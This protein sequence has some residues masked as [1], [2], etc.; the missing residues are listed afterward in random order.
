MLTT[1]TIEDIL[2]WNRNYKNNR[3]KGY[4]DVYRIS[5]EQKMYGSFYFLVNY[6]FFRENCNAALKKLKLITGAENF[7]ETNEIKEWVIFHQW[8]GS[9]KLVSFLVDYN[10]DVEHSTLEIV[11]LN[12]FVELNTFMPLVIFCEVFKI[13]YRELQLHLPESERTFDES[14]NYYYTSPNPL[15]PH[16]RIKNWLQKFQ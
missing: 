2:E 14:G 5:E 13:L 12:M 8:L 4:A 9:K 11:G 3:Q 6:Y 10:V 16:V 1:L 7:L 15:S